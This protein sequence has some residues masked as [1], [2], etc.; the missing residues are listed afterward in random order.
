MGETCCWRREE[1]FSGTRFLVGGKIRYREKQEGADCGETL[2]SWAGILV[3]PVVEI[4]W[5]KQGSRASEGLTDVGLPSN[6]D[7]PGQVSPPVHKKKLVDLRVALYV[8][9][10]GPTNQRGYQIRD[11]E[12]NKVGAKDPRP[13]D[14]LWVMSI[15]GRSVGYFN[16][17]TS[18]VIALAAVA[19]IPARDSIP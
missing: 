6:L 15:S 14:A 9:G 10:E 18:T 3:G 17:S 19:M 5:I 7:V 11:E 2:V 4:R 12:E 8:N 16:P 13:V 1:G